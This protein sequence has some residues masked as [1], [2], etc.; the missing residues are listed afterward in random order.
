VR[1]N[2]PH[3]QLRIIA[4]RWRGRRL[5]FAPVPGLR[6]T[7]DRVRETLFNWLGPV[8]AG[9]RCLDLFAGSGALGLEAAS[10]GAGEVV[11]VD[12]HATVIETL[13]QQLQQLDAGQVRVVQTEAAVYLRGGGQ[14]F[15]IVFLDPPFGE[16]LL[17]GIIQQLEAGGWL[18]ADA[19]IY[20]EA[21][22]GQVCELPPNWTV[23][24]SKTAG[25]VAYSLVRRTA[26][27]TP[28]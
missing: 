7:P 4:G 18:S 24:R 9:A 21:E 22:R 19:W 20:L 8:I 23:H 1:S 28:D 5:R 3:N 17:V 2:K 6:P 14:P 11:L 27:A 25:Q 12:S 15:D 10:R 16:G 13:R 26:A